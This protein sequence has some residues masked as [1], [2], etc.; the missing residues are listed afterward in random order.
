M[1]RAGLAPRWMSRDATLTTSATALSA[2]APSRACV[3][4][5]PFARGPASSHGASSR[6]VDPYQV[7][8]AHV[9]Q[10]LK[11]QGEQVDLAQTLRAA[12]H[13]ASMHA[14]PIV[15][16]NTTD[17]A[18]QRAS[19]AK[20]VID[21][22]E[23][24]F[25]VCHGN[26]SSTSARQQSPTSASAE[27]GA[28][29]TPKSSSSPSLGPSVMSLV[30]RLH[31][32]QRESAEFAA[33]QC[34][35]S[36]AELFAT[37]E[38]YWTWKRSQ[39]CDDGVWED[40]EAGTTPATGSLASTH[41]AIDGAT[42]ASRVSQPRPSQRQRP[43]TLRQR[44]DQALRVRDEL[45]SLLQ[46]HSEAVR[47]LDVQVEQWRQCRDSAPA[48]RSAPKWLTASPADIVGASGTVPRVTDTHAHAQRREFEA[49]ICQLV[50]VTQATHHIAQ[51]LKAALQA[52]CRPSPHTM[53][54]SVMPSATAVERIDRFSG[55]SK[56]LRQT[57]RNAAHSAAVD[58][59]RL[60]R[61]QTRHSVN[62]E[63]LAA[64]GISAQCDKAHSS[65]ELSAIASSS[66]AFRTGGTA[67]RPGCSLR[68]SRHLNDR[69]PRQ[70]A[71]P[72]Q[73]GGARLIKG[74]DDD[75]H[76]S[77]TDALSPLT[78]PPA[79]ATA[80]VSP[81]TP[82]PHYV[83]CSE[84]HSQQ[85]RR[86]R[87]SQ[88]RLS[89]SLSPPSAA[90]Q[91]EGSASLAAASCASSR[92]ASPSSAGAV[93]LSPLTVQCGAAT[94][95]AAVV[96]AQS[97]EES[98][99]RDHQRPDPMP[100]LASQPGRSGKSEVSSGVE[101]AVTPIVAVRLAVDGAAPHDSD[102]DKAS[103]LS[104]DAEHPSWP[105]GDCLSRD[106]ARS[107]LRELTSASADAV[108]MEG[109]R[110]CK[111]PQSA[112]SC[113][114]DVRE[115]PAAVD[116]ALWIFGEAAT[117]Y[118]PPL[119]E[120]PS[121]HSG[122]APVLSTAP[123]FA[124]V[125]RSEEGRTTSQPSPS[126]SLPPHH[127]LEAHTAAAPA[128][129]R[130]SVSA[131]GSTSL[132]YLSPRSPSMAGAAGR[133]PACDEYGGA[134]EQGCLSVGRAASIPT[135]LWPQL[136]DRAASPS[137]SSAVRMLASADVA[138]DAQPA[139]STT[140][141]VPVPH[142]SSSKEEE[143]SRGTAITHSASSTADVNFYTARDSDTDVSPP[144]ALTAALRA[145]A[146]T[147][148]TESMSRL[149]QRTQHPKQQQGDQQPHMKE[150]DRTVSSTPLLLD[151][152][153]SELVHIQQRRQELAPP[154]HSLPALSAGSAAAE[155]SATAEA[156]RR[157]LENRVRLTMHE[158]LKALRA[159]QRH[160]LRKV[161][162][163]VK[164]TL[165]EVAEAVSAVGSRNQSSRGS[166]CLSSRGRPSATA[167][168]GND[169]GADSL[170][171]DA[172]PTL[173]AEQQLRA[174]RA[175][176]QVQT[177]VLAASTE[178][179]SAPASNAPRRSAAHPSPL[180][181]TGQQHTAP[182]V[183]AS[184]KAQELQRS[185]AVA[186]AKAARLEQ[187]TVQLKKRL[188]MAELAQLSPASET[189]LPQKPIGAAK[190]RFSLRDAFVYGLSSEAGDTE[191]D[192]GG[193]SEARHAAA[194]EGYC[195]DGRTAA[196]GV[197]VE[198]RAM[199][200]LVDRELGCCT[201][202]DA[203]AQSQQRPSALLHTA[204][205]MSRSSRQ[206]SCDGSGPSAS[207]ER[208]CSPDMRC[209][210][211]DTAAAFL[212]AIISAPAGVT[213]GLPSRRLDLSSAAP[214]SATSITSAT[215]SPGIRRQRASIFQVLRQSRAAWD[216][217]ASAPTG[218][219]QQRQ[220]GGCQ[221]SPSPSRQHCRAGTMAEGPAV[222]T[223]RAPSAEQSSPRRQTQR[224]GQHPYN[225]AVA[226]HGDQRN[227]KERAIVGGL[228]PSV[229][230]HYYTGISEDS[231]SDS[232]AG[233]RPRSPASASALR[234][235]QVL[236]NAKRL[237]QSRSASLAA[238]H[239]DIRNPWPSSAPLA[240]GLSSSFS[241]VSSAKRCADS[242]E[243]CLET[244]HRHGG[245]TT[246]GA[247]ASPGGYLSEP[248]Q[249]GDHVEQLDG[250]F[251]PPHAFADA[252][253]HSGMTDAALRLRC[254][255]DSQDRRKGDSFAT[256]GAHESHSR[257]RSR[258]P[259]SDYRGYDTS[260]CSA[261]A[262]STGKLP[263]ASS[264]PGA[265]AAPS[266]MGQ[267]SSPPS[268]VAGPPLRA[269]MSRAATS[270]TTARHAR[271]RVDSATSPAPRK[272]SEVLA[273][274]DRGERSA[275]SHSDVAAH[276][277]ERSARAITGYTECGCSP[278]SI[279]TTASRS[280]RGHRSPSSL[281]HPTAEHRVHDSKQEASMPLTSR[282]SRSTS[283]CPSC[284]K[285][286]ASSCGSA[287]QQLLGT[288]EEQE[289]TLAAALDQ[290]QMQRRQLREKHQQVSLLVK[291]K[292]LV[293][294]VHALPRTTHYGG[295]RAAGGATANAGKQ[296]TR[297]RDGD[298][299]GS[300]AA[301]ETSHS[302]TYLHHLLQRLKAA[303][304]S[305]TDREQRVRDAL[306]VV[307]RQRSALLRD[308]LL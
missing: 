192:D 184:P 302:S 294:A 272:D 117:V 175:S 274:A 80:S 83:E 55:A 262:Y 162:K 57:G 77:W 25:P 147:A 38:A 68:S 268:V 29:P 199:L 8:R 58:E 281:L 258:S 145:Y 64:S 108:A 158:E 284:S 303:E 178:M 191:V 295:Q 144:P 202:W 170:G 229:C 190:R 28:P 5:A 296:S 20:S 259:G 290:L 136:H 113:G 36:V 116:S 106:G 195:E 75:T 109:P 276:H 230:S 98:I 125:T 102:G 251:P 134:G 89:P 124:D 13:I 225:A 237:L 92:C 211:D 90:A 183:P 213:G 257:S 18:P 120:Q 52:L 146:S 196:D 275:S 235:E 249:W 245:G 40:E 307:Q 49:Y 227:A 51:L 292:T 59:G 300:A 252:D 289:S 224:L 32:L 94:T 210:E 236:Q 114:R 63:G 165:E 238:G 82:S 246:G 234:A 157:S 256:D 72:T 168:E 141:P 143:G 148:P 73:C 198:E 167:H 283:Q 280:T 273:A 222:L 201:A 42:K 50:E 123:E 122:G 242:R 185:L 205:E 10:L 233:A 96:P 160:S 132:Q 33:T 260:P 69:T 179:A 177:E 71:K 39:M 151:N 14:E 6:G 61:L 172:R 111:S 46:L 1:S 137:P 161:R 7:C 56:E 299:D 74:A 215:R 156:L 23:N 174:A 219:R 138:E 104:A 203:R 139:Q 176:Q 279:C 217:Q 306:R 118:V 62:T 212:P 220:S 16:A 173:T 129:T 26:H 223:P 43:P 278:P 45:L 97:R 100:S 293:D 9:D 200:Y 269:D 248:R 21:N 121:C 70:R 291:R 66:L 285:S 53:V 297:A 88:R 131:G 208:E 232:V 266:S 239:H 112:G 133:S 135:C 250:A 282:L 48:S 298:R 187:L 301:G 4:T 84:P 76:G 308:D 60:G 150:W 277:R 182:T 206:V 37:F 11:L 169:N 247:S 47:A 255:S 119:S 193:W 54:P 140:A 130:A 31:V 253:P 101:A 142:R 287:Q 189:R 24:F 86:Q 17:G 67:T 154:R 204:G 99:G 79:A 91:T 270:A 105:R 180:L 216:A 128:A 207:T 107:L 34:M 304:S 2:S 115:G 243:H 27:A 286:S 152:L 228:R 149:L 127:T 95:A 267:R 271:R 240:G 153:E 35:P 221:P 85:L 41:S 288:L 93:S 126:P 264:P 110:L 164:H 171:G 103:R 194:S 226:P 197:A 214:V 218:Q 159:E 163:Y 231:G 12:L 87:H 44:Y 30:H 155:S 22:A 15:E 181:H 254:V 241:A 188:W 19:A 65:T 209:F 244:R 166:S 78:P 265:K 186:E 305:L 263:R 3:T 81:P 261:V